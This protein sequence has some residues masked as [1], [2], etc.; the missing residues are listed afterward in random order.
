M[1]KLRREREGAE[2]GERDRGRASPGAGST[3]LVSSRPRAPV[4]Q[5][6]TGSWSAATAGG[7]TAASRMRIPRQARLETTAWSGTMF[8]PTVHP[9]P[10]PQFYPRAPRI[11]PD[12]AQVDLPS[13]GTGVFQSGW[14]GASVG[15]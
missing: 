6:A 4:D 7:Q 14:S 12:G 9:L 10:V 15:M 2:R 11:G 8:A 3:G 5:R 13:L 1:E